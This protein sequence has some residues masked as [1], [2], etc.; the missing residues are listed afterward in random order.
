MFHFYT[1]W[2]CVHVGDI[3]LSSV[4]VGRRSFALVAEAVSWFKFRPWHVRCVQYIISVVN[5]WIAHLMLWMCQCYEVLSS[6]LMGSM[7]VYKLWP[8][9]THT[10]AHTP[11]LREREPLYP[12]LIVFTKLFTHVQFVHCCIPDWTYI[13]LRFSCHKTRAC[14]KMLCWLG[15]FHSQS[16]YSWGRSS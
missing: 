6:D 2:M 8:M 14:L 13:W 11:P 9:H 3:Y 5:S 12:R 1:N 4:C 16:R 7:S 15:H 10:D